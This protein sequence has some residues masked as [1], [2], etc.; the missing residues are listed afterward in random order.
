LNSKKR[1]NTNY[2]Y[3]WNSYQGSFPTHSIT[4]HKSK[5]KD[6]TVNLGDIKD[7][8]YNYDAVLDIAL[9]SNDVEKCNLMEEA[10]LCYGGY[11]S[12]TKDPEVCFQSPDQYYCLRT[13]FK[14]MGI[15][16][17]DDLSGEK[18]DVC[19]A[20]YQAWESR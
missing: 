1:T 11:A 7:F 17:C 20:S 13:L 9:Y 15:D 6:T 19:Q 14:K 4:I 18:F 8:R 10:Y 5:L 3:Y 12:K 2:C 16:V